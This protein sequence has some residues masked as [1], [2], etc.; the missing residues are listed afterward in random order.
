[1]QVGMF[2][3][4]PLIR[5]N[6]VVGQPL[7]L[8]PGGFQSKEFLVILL[9]GRLGIWH[10]LLHFCL[11]MASVMTDWLVVHVTRFWIF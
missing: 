10:I 9:F 7:L 3:V 4:K 2:S 1:M 6:V 5:L 8:L 11:L